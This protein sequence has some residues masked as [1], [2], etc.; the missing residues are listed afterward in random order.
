MMGEPEPIKRDEWMQEIT[1]LRVI[2]E[3][4]QGIPWTD[5]QD[6]FLKEARNGE[7]PIPLRLLTQAILKFWNM[8][9]SES[10]VRRRCARLGLK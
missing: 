6:E 3:R 9:I 7:P 1:R 4:G 8:R 5:E 2:A 10:A